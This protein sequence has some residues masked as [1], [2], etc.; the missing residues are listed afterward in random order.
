M[1]C[2]LGESKPSEADEEQLS[3][4]INAAATLAPGMA[5]PHFYQPNVTHC[6]GASETSFF[7]FA[8]L[9]G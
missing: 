7:F 5:N 9:I 1:S 8:G 4:V 3:Q 2:L 6:F